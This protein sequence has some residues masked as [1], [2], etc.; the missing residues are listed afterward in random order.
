MNTRNRFIVTFAFLLISAGLLALHGIKPDCLLGRVV[1]SS[2]LIMGTATLFIGLLAVCQ[3]LGPGQPEDG[4]VFNGRR[5]AS[6]PSTAAP[7][8]RDRNGQTPTTPRPRRR[9]A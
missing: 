5:A 4:A 2:A 1:L 8:L 9:A 6:S 7:A 3:W